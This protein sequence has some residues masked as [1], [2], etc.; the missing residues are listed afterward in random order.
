MSVQETAK[1]LGVPHGT[2]KAQAARARAKLKLLMQKKVL[3][4]KKAN[5]EFL[6]KVAKK[7]PCRHCAVA[8]HH[9]EMM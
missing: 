3:R 5:L 6:S 7:D 1:I 8:H 9:K 4:E 2:V